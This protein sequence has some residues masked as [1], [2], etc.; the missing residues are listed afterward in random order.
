MESKTKLF[1]HPIH[2]MLVVFPLG[3]LMMAVIFD[4]IALGLG[5]GYWSGIAY[6][7][8]GAGVIGGLAA[9]M[10]GLIDW[11]AIPSN[12]RATK[13]GRDSS[14][15]VRLIKD[16]DHS[17]TDKHVLMVED[18]IDTGLTLS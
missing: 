17:I 14:G 8:I 13:V 12:T 4:L 1:G 6:Y 18:V 3:L 16:L 11:L 10:F 7:L 2:P 5:S 9:A 15:V